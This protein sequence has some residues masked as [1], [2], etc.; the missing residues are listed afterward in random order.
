LFVL[1][2]GYGARRP[3]GDIFTIHTWVFGT[4][5]VVCTPE[6]VQ[7]V[8]SGSPDVYHAGEANGPLRVLL[9][10]R[11]VLLLD[12]V[13]HVRHRRVM[14]P[15]FHGERMRAYAS[16]MIDITERSIDGWPLGK[17]F[18]LHPHMQQITL[19]IILRTVFGLE[20]GPRREVL[21]AA[22]ARLLDL[23]GSRLGFVGLN[24]KLQRDLGP[25]K[26]WSDFK[27]HRAAADAL[28]H[29][30]IARR[31]AE[32]G[33]AERDDVLAL[34]L[35]ARDEAG[36]PLGDAELRD[37]LMTLLAAGHETTATA[38]CWAF[39]QILR[40]PEVLARIR[41]ELDEV[42]GGATLA[43]DHLASLEYL[44]ATIK[45]ALRVRP[46][47]PGV[48]RV[49][50]APVVLGGYRLPAGTMVAPSVYLTHHN[51]RLYPEPERFRPERFLGKK[52]DPYGWLPFGG[53][54]RRCVGMAFALYEMKI[55]LA[56]VLGRARLRLTSRKPLDIVLR[57]FVFA[58]EGGTR[59][60]MEARRTRP[61][62]NDS[63]V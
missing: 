33:G 24:P 43:P 7:Q 22:L 37:E 57:S 1:R 20:E 17:R 32:V 39:E 52:P 40:H 6:L 3:W 28:I 2:P 10:D 53:G 12:G 8:F 25:Y 54:A 46:P 50:K 29:E 58:P 27:R 30:Q 15:P 11:S 4:E 49:L 45:E 47:V 19:D 9:G 59:V 16:A 18:A 42:T 5:V 23:V 41:R 48:G 60:V 13:E 34:L 56:A 44:D 61:R 55:V 62:G 35:A 21:R 51:P 38:L 31:R 63:R 26:P 36:E 14:L